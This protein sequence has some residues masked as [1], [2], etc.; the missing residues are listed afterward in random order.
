MA[1]YRGLLIEVGS[2]DAETV[3]AS[4]PHV[5]ATKAVSCSTLLIELSWTTS[6][7]DAQ[8]LASLGAVGENSSFLLSAQTT[9]DVYVIDEY[10]DQRLLRHVRYCA[11]CEPEWEATGTA[12]A[13]EE[14]LLFALPREEFIEYLSDDSG[15]SEADL[16]RAAQAHGAKSRALLP[17]PPRLLGASF[18]RWLTGKGVDPRAPHGR[19]EKRKALAFIRRVLPWWFGS[20]AR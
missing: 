7:A 14:A 6:A 2:R 8:A 10:F 5:T 19:Y 4:L 13:W 1:S 20:S 3:L 11:E 16:V 12:R 17:H 9:T 18:W 15:Y